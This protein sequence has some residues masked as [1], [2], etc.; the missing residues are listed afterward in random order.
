M[1]SGTTCRPLFNIWVESPKNAGVNAIL[2]FTFQELG[3]IQYCAN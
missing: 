2:N 3:N 1:T